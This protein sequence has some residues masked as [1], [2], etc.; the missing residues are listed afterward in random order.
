MDTDVAGDDRGCSART[1]P[2]R[3]RRETTWSPAPPTTSASARAR[4]ARASGRRSTAANEQSDEDTITLPEGT[5]QL[6]NGPL[7]IDSAVTMRGRRRQRRR[8]V[9]DGDG[10][11]VLEITGATAATLTRSRCRAAAPTTSD[12]S[13]GGTLWT[14]DSTVAL[15]RVRVHRR[16]GRERRRDRQPQRL[17]ARS[18][19]RLIDN[20]RRPRGR[21]RRRRDHQLRRRRLGPASLTIN[22]S[23]I[24]FNTARLAGG[25]I[26]YGNGQTTLLTTA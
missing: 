14:Q 19:S 9:A 20:N 5:I 23:T 25:L 12:G 18:T 7:P 17:D 6:T 21:W 8:S 24:A 22:S 2:C 13:H 10:G 16:H 15:N 11:R 26:S 1:G 3:E 4:R